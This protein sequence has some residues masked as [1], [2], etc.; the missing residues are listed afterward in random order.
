VPA[1]NFA[2]TPAMMQKYQM[3]TSLPDRAHGTQQDGRDCHQ[4]P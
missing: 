2:S 1:F 3:E 4:R